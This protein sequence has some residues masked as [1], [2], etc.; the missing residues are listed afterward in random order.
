MIK[1]RSLVALL[2]YITARGCGNAG[3]KIDRTQSRL[4]DRARFI[5]LKYVS[6]DRRWLSGTFSAVL[7]FDHPAIHF[8]SAKLTATQG[9]R[10]VV[11]MTREPD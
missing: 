8:K 9:K 11:K 5:F 7:S 10:F 2:W 3:V 4:L 1:A 6:L